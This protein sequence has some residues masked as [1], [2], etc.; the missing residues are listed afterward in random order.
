ES[1]PGR[2]ELVLLP[3]GTRMIVQT[4]E[5]PSAQ[6][7]FSQVV[8]QGRILY[9]NR[10]SEQVRATVNETVGTL[11][12]GKPTPKSAQTLQKIDDLTKHYF[13]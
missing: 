12:I 9:P 13:N 6:S 11:A 7:L 1:L 2:P 10:D 3:D 4:G 5:I 8:D